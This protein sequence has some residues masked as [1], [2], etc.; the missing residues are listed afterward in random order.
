MMYDRLKEVFERGYTPSILAVA[1]EI[2]FY[3]E[4]RTS[5]VQ[6]RQVA[7]ILR[8]HGYLPP[9][10]DDATGFIPGRSLEEKEAYKMIS[11][12]ITVF[13]AN[14]AVSAPQLKSPV[15]VI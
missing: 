9:R 15:L 1:E 13:E 6:D 12:M 14:E 3:A 4:I 11:R 8:R 10:A 2:N 5:R 7:A